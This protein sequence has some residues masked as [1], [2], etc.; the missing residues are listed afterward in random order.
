[1]AR[2]AVALFL[3]IGAVSPAALQGCSCAGNTHLTQNGNIGPKANHQLNCNCA[4]NITGI[5]QMFGGAPATIMVPT[6]LCLPPDLNTSVGGELDAS[7]MQFNADVKSYC[8]NRVNTIMSKLIPF[9]DSS[10]CSQG[11][12]CIASISCEPQAGMGG[13][14]T[15]ANP[16]CDGTCANVPCVLGPIPE[17]GP[18]VDGNLPDGFG[19][20]DPGKVLPKGA[21]TADPRFCKCTQATGCSG[22]TE[23][24]CQVPPG[25]IDPPVL[26]SGF[27]TERLAGPSRINLDPTAS[28][29][30]THVH[31]KGGLGESHD[32]TETTSVGGVVT[33]Y[34]HPCPGSQC[35]MLMDMD[36]HPAD[37][38]FH[39]SAVVCGA[40]CIQD[41]NVTAA[42]VSVAGGM[43]HIPV[44][45][46]SNGMGSIPLGVLNLHAESIVSGI[47][48]QPTQREI[49][50]APN[51]TPLAFQ[52]D[53]TNKTF[54]LPNV[55]FTLAGGDGD[56]HMTLSGSIA[57]QPPNA[58]AGPDQVLECNSFAGGT[59]TLDGSQSSD[60]D[61]VLFGYEWWKGTAFDS[62]VLAGSG[63]TLNV[64]QPIGGPV[65][66]QLSVL[67]QFLDISV[68]ST[69][70][71]VQD[72]TPPTLTL[73]AAPSCL[74][75][76]D[77]SLV[78]YEIGAGLN[79]TAQD[80]CDPSPTVRI[81]DVQSNQPANGGGS[82]NTSPDVFFKDDAFCVRSE[83]EGTV[84]TPREYTVTVQ[85]K[86]FSGNTTTKTTI[87]T[88]GHDQAG[89]KC[90]NVDRSLVVADGDPRCGTGH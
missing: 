45:I 77:H 82:G 35:D 50:D 55:P 20:C 34:G 43:G 78:L 53:F 18:P 14:D 8:E 6:Q 61:G 49:F 15:V 65:E 11:D 86:D 63:K 79:A 47:P 26:V 51:S 76:P 74:W 28:S 38:T 57:N 3:L 10:V 44:H 56:A 37:V 9:L 29:V 19:N 67:D 80:T 25:N 70:V 48:N 12:R 22:T 75:P 89:M 58:V 88:V 52:V 71:K 54:T 41:V 13:L 64:T 90:P 39:F 4:V 66:Y 85:A 59:V 27:M 1:M 30:T 69:H 32:D 81:V 62:N 40:F 42:R 87:I 21:T 68:D 5:C 24:F 60:A 84:A 73:S 33:L 31:F 2:R 36:L 83:R 17:G 72:T 46:L 23:Q 7:D 16:A